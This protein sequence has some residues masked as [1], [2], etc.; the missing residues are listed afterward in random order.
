M[1]EILVIYPVGH[2]EPSLNL[3]VPGMGILQLPPNP[4][5]QILCLDPF[6]L[7]STQSTV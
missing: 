2:K 5:R 4:A 3:S 7:G 1:S 6:E